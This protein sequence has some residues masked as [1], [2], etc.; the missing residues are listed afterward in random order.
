MT[1]WIITGALAFIV[2]L[3]VYAEV[4]CGR[5]TKNFLDTLAP[6]IDALNDSV[7]RK[8]RAKY[9]KDPTLQYPIVNLD[10]K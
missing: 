3:I 9:G 2:V 6:E 7:L 1:T 5:R 4:R 8:Y 10:R